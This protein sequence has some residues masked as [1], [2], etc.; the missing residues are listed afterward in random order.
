MVR[1]RRPVSA[2]DVEQS[3]KPRPAALPHDR[4]ALDDKGA[5]EPDQRHDVGDGRER[6]EVEGSEQI[7]A[8][9]RRSRSLLRAKPD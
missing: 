1:P 3:G 6:D 5:V 2:G 4:K 8:F 7:R 9:A